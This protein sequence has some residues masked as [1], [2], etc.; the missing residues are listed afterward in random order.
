MA[1]AT[2]TIW[3]V[4]TTGAADNGGGFHPAAQGAGTDYSRQDA[5]QLV[6]TDLEADGE[7][8]AIVSTAGGFTPAMVGNLIYISSITGAWNAEFYEI[9]SYVDTNTVTL[10]RNPTW[11]VPALGG[12][13]KVGGAQSNLGRVC[14]A[15]PAASAAGANVIHVKAGTYVNGTHFTNQVRF[16]NAGHYLNHHVVRGYNATRG[17]AIAPCVMLDGNNAN[18][19]VYYSNKAYIQLENIAVNGYAGGTPTN[20][21]HG[22]NL[23][24][25]ADGNAL[26]RCRAVNTGA[27]GI[28]AVAN[29]CRIE[30]CEAS[31]FGRAASSFGIGVGGNVVSLVGCHAHDG[32]GDAFNVWAAY[33]GL[34]AY[35]IGAGCT[36]YGL[37]MNINSAYSVQTVVHGVFHGNG[38]HGIYA[39]GSTSG[40]PGRIV[41]TIL[42]NNGG[43]GIAAH[44]TGKCRAILLGVAFH[45]NTSGQIDGNVTVEEA[46]ARL[47]L[48]GDPFVDAAGGDFRLKASARE[49]LGSGWPG[50]FLRNGAMTAWAGH[51]DY[52]AVQQ[53]VRPVGVP[54]TED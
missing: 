54:R 39:A 51:P 45:G 36:Q 32:T 33:P 42:S 25:G 52:G 46:V 4:R 20:A 43:Y 22:F 19:D 38:S 9:V 47:T 3:E 28:R 27:Q 17:D 53:A 37:N 15:V 14:A 16:N 1:L 21:R 48:S 30:G 31:G 35:C 11:G 12:A 5:A 49:A 44:G 10:D 7:V 26:Y 41:N 40:R 18:Y 13:G 6:L 24:T 8:F 34:L 50:A 29:G 23:D 2:T